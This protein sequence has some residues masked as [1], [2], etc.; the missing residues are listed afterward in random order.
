M[1]RSWCGMTLRVA[2]DL[3]RHRL[4]WILEDGE[5]GANVGDEPRRVDYPEPKGGHD[6][7]LWIADRV[8]KASDPYA[9]DPLGF[10]WLSRGAAERAAKAV[11]AAL[12]ERTW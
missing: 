2:S 10:F 1:K 6:L 12:N 3:H 9:T 11:R 7:V 8:A 5:D 4:I